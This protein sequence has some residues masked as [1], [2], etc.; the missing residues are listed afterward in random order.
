M[1]TALAV[2][3]V[4]LA[5]LSAHSALMGSMGDHGMSDIAAICLAVGASLAIAGVAVFAIRRLA[6]RPLWVIPVPAAPAAAFVPRSTAFLARAGPP[7]LLQ[8]FRL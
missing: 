1:L 2:L 4:A 8:V 7:P 5:A 6:Q 3:S